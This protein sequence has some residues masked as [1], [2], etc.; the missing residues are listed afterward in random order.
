MGCRI[1]AVV[2][3]KDDEEEVHEHEQ[4]LDEGKELVGPLPLLDVSFFP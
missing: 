3:H 1:L 2:L 4:P